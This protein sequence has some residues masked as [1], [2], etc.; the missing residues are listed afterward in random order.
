VALADLIRAVALSSNGEQTFAVDFVTPG[1]Q[2]LTFV[3]V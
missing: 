2:A 1:I 3:S